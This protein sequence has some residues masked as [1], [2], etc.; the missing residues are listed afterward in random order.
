MFEIK[1][2]ELDLSGKTPLGIVVMVSTYN[3]KWVFCKHKQRTTW[4][5]PGGHI[6]PGESPLDA[7]K[8]EL[9]EETGATKAKITPVC[10]YSISK[11]GILCH[12]EI[13][14][15]KGLPES[16]IEKI[17]F[18][19]ELPK[20]LTYPEAHTLFFETVKEFLNKKQN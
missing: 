2:H 20:N 14:E 19:D 13:E 7:A 18:F 3:G 12:A 8:R 4:E 15:L 6:E 9:F 16:E 1:L 5:I 17:E 11:F 10:L